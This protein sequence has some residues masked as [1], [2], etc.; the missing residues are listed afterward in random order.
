VA[1]EVDGL[2]RKSA[3]TDATRARFVGQ[4]INLLAGV[5]DD[6]SHP[7]LHSVWQDIFSASD[8]ADVD[9]RSRL[10]EYS[11]SQGYP[12]LRAW[13]AE[14]EN[15]DPSRILITAGGQHGLFLAVQ[16]AVQKDS[17][18]AVDNPIFPLFLRILELRTTRTLPIPVVAD[19]LDTDALEAQ[20]RAGQE[21]SAVYT[22]PDFHNPTTATLSPPAQAAPGGPGR[23]IRVLGDCRQPLP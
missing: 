14:R 3:F 1:E 15:V 4:P 23:G 8:D 12:E 22:V 20:L 13:I 9:V 19:G 5:P 21:I 16:L 17:L 7:D 6:E 11:P 10:F 18:V 2:Q